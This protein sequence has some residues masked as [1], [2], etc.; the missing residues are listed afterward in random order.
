[1][2]SHSDLHVPVPFADMEGVLDEAARRGVGAE[3]QAM[4]H[5]Q[6]LGDAYDESLARVEK[7][8]RGFPGPVSVHG[9]F[10][11]LNPVS[12]DADVAS[13]TR[14]R[15]EQAYELARATGAV[16]LLFHSQCSTFIR[17]PGYLS[18]WLERSAAFWTGWEKSHPGENL[19]IVMENVFEPDWKPLSMLVDAVASPRFGACLDV[20]HA[21]L[22]SK[23]APAWVEGFGDRLAYMHFHD[24]DGEWDRHLS[25]GEGNADVKGVLDALAKRGNFCRMNLEV[26]SREGVVQAVEW[27]KAEGYLEGSGS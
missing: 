1:M 14:R 7:A 10:F 19:R 20:G 24:N 16:V 18:T 4:V 25:P 17:D 27:M 12:T 8:F 22:F 15:Y 23:D 6:H 3:I 21:H 26:F 2:W 5:P 9:P 11:D 13:A